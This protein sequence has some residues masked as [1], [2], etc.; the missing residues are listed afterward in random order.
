[1]GRCMSQTN[2][3]YNSNILLYSFAFDQSVLQI[4]CSMLRLSTFHASCCAFCRAFCHVHARRVCIIF[5]CALSLRGLLLSFARLYFCLLSPS[6]RLHRYRGRRLH[7]S[8]DCSCQ[9]YK[10]NS[11]SIY[12]FCY[13]CFRFPLRKYSSSSLCLSFL[14][15]DSLALAPNVGWLLFLPST[16]AV[17]RFD[18]FSPTPVPT[19][20]PSFFSAVTSIYAGCTRLWYR[21]LRW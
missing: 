14:A 10:L 18:Y 13:L 17:E 3:C 2:H 21:L 11:L 12:F 9:R 1:M 7:R 4:V 15:V 6:C 8:L 19:S 5:H 20:T 16:P